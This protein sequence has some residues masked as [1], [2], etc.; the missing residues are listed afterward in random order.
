MEGLKQ[1]D[2][3]IRNWFFQESSEIIP[4]RKFNPKPLKEV[5]GEKIKTDDEELNNGLAKTRLILITSPIE[6]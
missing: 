5:A 6:Y 2:I 4:I 3:I 1:E